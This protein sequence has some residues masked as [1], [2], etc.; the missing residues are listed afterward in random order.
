MNSHQRRVCERSWL[1]A[2]DINHDD[3]L[4]T[5]CSAWLHDNFGSNRFNRRRSPRWCFRLNYDSVSFARYAIGAQIYFRKERDYLAF[6]LK[7]G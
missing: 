6:I 1:H 4:L 3:E 2:I 7:F 5:E